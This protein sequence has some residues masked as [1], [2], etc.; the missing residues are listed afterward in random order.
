MQQ[1]ETVKRNDTYSGDRMSI[2]YEL[3][4]ITKK[5]ENHT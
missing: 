3:D 2:V 1:I 5:M 4:S